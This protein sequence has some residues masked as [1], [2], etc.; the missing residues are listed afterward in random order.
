VSLRLR[1][2]IATAVAVLAALLVVDAA[3]YVVVTRSLTRQV[4]DTLGEVH[5][6]IEQL[7]L[8]GVSDQWDTIPQIAPG[9]L[10]TILDGDG[11]ALFTTPAQGPGQG[12]NT[13]KI[14]T[15]NLSTRSS[16]T[17]SIEGNPMRLRIERL[18]S[19]DTLI[20]GK[21]LH[22]VN[23]T[24]HRLLVVLLM[25]TAAAIGL[26]LAMAWWL[27]RVGLRPLRR[28][29]TSAAAISDHELS[30]YRVPGAMEPTEV[31]GLARTLNAMLD[32]LDGARE[33]RERTMAELRVSEDR[34][35]RFVAD[36]SH[37]LRTPVAAAAAYAELFEGGARDRPADLDRAM[38]GIRR[39]TARMGEL[40]DDLLVLARLDEGRPLA[41][42]EVDLTEIVLTAIDAART[43]EPD[44]PMRVKIDDVVM[45]TGDPL[46]LR[47]VVDNLLANVRAHTPPSTPCDVRLGVDQGEPFLSVSDKGPGVTDEQLTHLFDR[48]YRAD[49]ARTRSTGGSGLGLAIVFA[50]VHA[51]GGSIAATHRLPH[52]LELTMRLPA[53][54]RGSMHEVDQPDE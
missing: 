34:M 47:Q 48:F 12:R 29:E 27:V 43:L 50:I 38:A 1:L 8:T 51:H 39:E 17:T 46:R 11:E 3:T 41:S 16:S 19:G 15:L 10:V 53:H 7:A 54:P 26:V 40:V 32:R 25:A 30:D 22:E 44:R 5:I 14:G 6:P 9:L 49:E 45:V 36:A 31:G 4:D 42:G 52:G 35:R 28:V 23:E 2:V 21:P 20:V 37:E 24:R 18:S 33:E 13:I